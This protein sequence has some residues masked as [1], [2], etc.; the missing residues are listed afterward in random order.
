M[1]ACAGKCFATGI[2]Q[3]TGLDCVM[4]HLIVYMYMLHALMVDMWAF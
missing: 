1:K 3:F 2:F 4:C